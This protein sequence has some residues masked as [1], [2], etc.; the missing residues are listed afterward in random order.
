MMPCA[1]GA[2]LLPKPPPMYWV[3]T[4]TLACGIPSPCAKPLRRSECTACVETHAVSLSP[5]HSQTHAVRLEA[6]V[7]DDVGRI[8]RLDDVRGRGEAGVEIAGLFGRA[9][10][11]VAVRE[12]R[13][14]VGRHRLLDVGEVRQRLVARHGPGGQ[15]RP[16]ALRC[17]PRRRRLGS[18]WYITCAPGCASRRAPPSRPAPSARRTRSIDTTRACG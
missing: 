8:G 13:R 12:H 11:G 7:R 3:M 15:R 16:R 4:R 10:A 9:L 18:P 5:S 6:H 14:R 1:S 17:R 2:N